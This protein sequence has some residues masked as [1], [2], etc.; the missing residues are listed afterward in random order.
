MK[1]KQI[2]AWSL[3]SGGMVVLIGDFFFEGL[4]SLFIGGVASGLMV[5][6]FFVTKEKK[7]SPKKEPPPAEKKAEI[8]NGR[9]QP[10]SARVELTELFVALAVLG[11][12]IAGLIALV[13]YLGNSAIEHSKEIAQS[14]AEPPSYAMTIPRDK[15]LVKSSGRIELPREQII[16]IAPLRQNQ[17]WQWSF[18]NVAFV[19]WRIV[20][21]FQKTADEKFR[22]LS[23]EDDIRMSAYK[24][25]W[26]QIR[27]RSDQN[28][29]EFTLF[30]PLLN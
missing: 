4:D 15:L 29:I 11:I 25:G 14:V 17:I 5:V 22:L 27:S 13:N 20:S 3:L 28:A 12:V 10:Q 19:E 9:Y 21:D 7:A 26:L 1:T 24:N 16:N 2:I 18:D 30:E 8:P 23:G 6:I